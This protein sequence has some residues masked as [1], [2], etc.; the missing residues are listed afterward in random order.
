M[1]SPY[2][3]FLRI[4]LEVWR[5]LAGRFRLSAWSCTP[6]GA[7]GYFAQKWDFC[8]NTHSWRNNFQASAKTHSLTKQPKLTLL[9][10]EW[11]ISQDTV[12]LY[13]RKC[14]LEYMYFGRSIFIN[15]IS[16]SFQCIH[17]EV[18]L[19][20][21]TC[22]LFIWSIPRK[23]SFYN[24]IFMLLIVELLSC[25]CCSVLFFFFVSALVSCQSC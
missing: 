14:V 12:M 24:Y 4:V 2:T 25:V 5:Q 17:E 21:C 23:T 8:S 13:E 18:R 19:T 6:R 20:T 16:F 9:L 22:K 10:L 3:L 15:D 7:A 1:P 11:R